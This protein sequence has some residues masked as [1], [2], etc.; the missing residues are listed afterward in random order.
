LPRSRES[1]R[2]NDLRSLLASSLDAIVVTD[3]DRR[4]V[5]A[6]AKALELFGIS[7]FNFRNFT[8]DAFV[9]NFDWSDSSF[10]RQEARLNR[11]Q[12]R[13]WTRIR[14]FSFRKCREHAARFVDI[15]NGRVF[16]C[17]GHFQTR[18]MPNRQPGVSY[19]P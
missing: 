14:R 5:A 9:P 8:L 6:N 15:T 1:A 12:F 16:L 3:S 4:L 10:E 2:E 18:S 7:E 17:A 19:L 13:E 11:C